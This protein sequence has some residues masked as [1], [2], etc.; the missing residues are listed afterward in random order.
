M[1]EREKN[2]GFYGYMGNHILYQLMMVKREN[3]S[4]IPLP[5]I[6]LDDW[7]RFGDTSTI[8]TGP[9]IGLYTKILTDM[10]YML[11]GDEKAVYRGDAGPYPW[12]EEG[13]YKLWNHLLSIYGIKGKNY[14][15]IAAIKS[16]EIFENLK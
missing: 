7:I 9:T 13:S 2:F 16:A 3:E 11:T 15:P 1:K 14:D 4:F 10:L 6:G 8:V 5:M 12:Q